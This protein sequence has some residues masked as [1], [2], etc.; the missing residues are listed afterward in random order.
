MNGGGTK[1]TIDG[2][3][4]PYVQGL[5]SDEDFLKVFDFEVLSGSRDFLGKNDIIITEE[6][7][8]LFFGEIDVVGKVLETE[9]N[10]PIYLTVSAVVRTPPTN[11]SIPFTYVV[12]GKLLGEM[13]DRQ[14]VKTNRQGNSLHIYFKTSTPQNIIDLQSNIDRA[15]SKH[16]DKNSWLSIFLTCSAPCRCSF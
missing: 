3:S 10:G 2:K 6:L 5:M 12:S 9:F 13:W 11:S 15:F 14:F 16:K 1:F 7:A 4:F 8:Q